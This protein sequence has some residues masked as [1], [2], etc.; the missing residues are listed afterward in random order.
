MMEVVKNDVIKLLDVG[1]IYPISDSVW[2]SPTHV[3]PKKFGITVVQNSN[4]ELIPTRVTSGWCV[5]IDYRKL[6]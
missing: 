2:V 1:I 5:C 3:V 4:N 6:N